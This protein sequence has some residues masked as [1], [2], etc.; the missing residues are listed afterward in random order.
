MASEVITHQPFTCGFG[1]IVFRIGS[2]QINRFCFRISILYHWLI[3]AGRCI[4][5]FRRNVCWTPW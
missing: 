5:V 2:I 3:T 4:R 1:H